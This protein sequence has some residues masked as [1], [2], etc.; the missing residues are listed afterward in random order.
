MFFNDFFVK[1]IQYKNMPHTIHTSYLIQV[2]DTFV[3]ADDLVH[4][5]VSVVRIR[6]GEKIRIVSSDLKLFGATVTAVDRNKLTILVN[7]PLPLPEAPKPVFLCLAL[8][9]KEK[10]EWIIEKA[11][12]L[13]ISGV[14][15][16]TA[17]RS[18]RD[19]LSDAKWQ[20]LLKIADEALKQCGRVVPLELNRFDS[21]TTLFQELQGAHMIHYFCD[22]QVSPTS[23]P[24]KLPN[25]HKAIWIGPEGGWDDLE[26]EF[27]SKNN[28]TFL[29]LSPLILRAETAAICAMSII[30][31]A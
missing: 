2:G 28:F 27:A 25:Q 14:Y 19:E 29:S 1:N 30:T 3:L 15:L 10:L 16:F 23:M 31:L 26:R 20:R 13:N 12:E 4:H 24:E 5:L 17:K 21:Q 8:L 18:V 22:E 9:K 11:V 7:E 6:I